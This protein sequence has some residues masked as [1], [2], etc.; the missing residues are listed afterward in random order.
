MASVDGLM[1]DFDIYQGAKFLEQQVH[2]NKPLGLGTMVHV[3]LS[4]PIFFCFS[5]QKRWKS[6]FIQMV[7]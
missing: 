1:L 3:R 4:R 2:P 5:N 6:C 7:L